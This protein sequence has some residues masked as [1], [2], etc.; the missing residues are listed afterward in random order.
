VITFNAAPPLGG[1]A[2]DT[3]DALGPLLGRQ[4]VLNFVHGIENKIRTEA[5]TGARKSIPDITAAVEHKAK[6]AIMPAV[7]GLAVASGL[8]L[9]VGGFA[10]YRTYRR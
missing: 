1:F 4:R 2:E 6:A 5:E 10:L 3:A 7:I 9:T 8:A